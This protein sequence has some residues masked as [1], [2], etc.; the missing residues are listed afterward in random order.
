MMTTS[1][2][3]FCLVTRATAFWYDDDSCEQCRY[4]EARAKFGNTETE[5]REA[6][7]E[8]RRRTLAAAAGKR[9]P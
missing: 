7:A 6:R 9:R 2:C 8:L 3:Q 1:T 5:K 4:L